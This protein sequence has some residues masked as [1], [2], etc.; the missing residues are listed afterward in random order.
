MSVR[1][2]IDIE[3]LSVP[4]AIEHQRSGRY[5]LTAR[6]LLPIGKRAFKAAD[7]CSRLSLIIVNAI[8][9]LGIFHGARIME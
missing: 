8:L 6:V 1:S 9:G 7:S 2:R 4:A 3:L 5:N